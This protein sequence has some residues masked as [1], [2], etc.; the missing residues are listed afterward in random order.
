MWE[1]RLAGVGNPRPLYN[2]MA[3]CGS[4][5]PLVQLTQITGLASVSVNVSLPVG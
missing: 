2:V 4:V 3:D 1:S 5:D